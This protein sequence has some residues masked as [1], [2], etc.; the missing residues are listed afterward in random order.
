MGR[1]EGEKAKDGPRETTQPRHELNTKRPIVGKENEKKKG[2]AER[3]PNKKEAPFG[4]K[5]ASC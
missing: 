1:H 2:T 4:L 3:G 5:N